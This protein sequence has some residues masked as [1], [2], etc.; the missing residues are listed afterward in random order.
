MLSTHRRL[1]H[2]L[3]V[4][5]R[6]V[7]T[8]LNELTDTPLMLRREPSSWQRMSWELLEVTA[9]VLS[10]GVLSISPRRPIVGPVK[11]RKSV[12]YPQCHTNGL[13]STR[14]S[15]KAPRNNTTTTR[16]GCKDRKRRALRK[17]HQQDSGGQHAY[18]SC[19]QERR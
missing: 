4:D 16:Q 15:G 12:Q 9:S 14:R 10:D 7:M 1:V 6:M 18:P 17:S 5:I 8:D 19:R 2:F 3:F 11:A 13:D